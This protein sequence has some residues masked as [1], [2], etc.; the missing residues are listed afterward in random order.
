MGR[1]AGSQ[2]IPKFHQRIMARAT[3]E[4]RAPLAVPDQALDGARRPIPPVVALIEQNL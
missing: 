4:L 2:G 3:V 1:H